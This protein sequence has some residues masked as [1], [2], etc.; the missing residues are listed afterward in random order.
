M[1]K[2]HAPPRDIIRVVVSGT[3]RVKTDAPAFR[4]GDSPIIVLTTEM[5]TPPRRAKLAA[6][7]TQVVVCGDREIDWPAALAWLRQ[8][9][10]IQR[11]LCEGGGTLNASLFAAGMVDELH[12][13]ICPFV[14][15]GRN[16]P[17]IAD[18]LAASRLT[19]AI[20]LIPVSVQKLDEELFCV[21]RV[22]PTKSDGA[23]NTTNSPRKGILSFRR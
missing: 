2:G 22:C 23:I 17:T 21:F 14:F 5:A 3:G 4:R 9:W 18:G 8:R 12:L 1:R 15:A 19:D 10:H 20:Q 7:A 11:L 13:T 6:A 16:A